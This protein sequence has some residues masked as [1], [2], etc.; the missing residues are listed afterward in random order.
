[1]EK[2]KELK[3]RIEEMPQRWESEMLRFVC[4]LA[5]QLSE[6]MF[7]EM[8][9]GLKQETQDMEIGGLEKSGFYVLPVTPNS[10]ENWTGTNKVLITLSVR[11]KVGA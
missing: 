10:R 1:M 2:R 5:R 7:K 4:H 3:G 11:R 6:E 8:D 9:D